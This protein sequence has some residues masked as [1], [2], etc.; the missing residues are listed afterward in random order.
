MAINRD[1]LR[2][3]DA[4]PPLGESRAR[5]LEALQQAGRALSAADLA[6]QLGVHQNTARFHLDALIEAGIVEKQVDTPEGPGRPRVLY[7]ARE[8]CAP[9]GQRSYRLL[10]EILTSFVAAE[11]P[12]ASAAALRAGRAWGHYLARRPAPFER[13]DA[14]RALDQLI[15]QLDEI[16]FAP[17]QVSSGG[18]ELRLRHCPFREAA[19]EH[20]QVVCS[21]HLGLMQG[22]LDDI[23]A[24]FEVE[25]LEPFVEPAL[26]VAHLKPRSAS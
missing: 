12:D 24:P 5:V 23:H 22:V 19:E 7:S 15:A 1:D 10:A 26:C 4:V 14:E 16:G 2:S 11:V 6:R 21:I 18:Q 3:P 17:E 8:G 9:A 25:R 20:R 13:V